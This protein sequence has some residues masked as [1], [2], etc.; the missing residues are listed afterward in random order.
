MRASGL[1]N[2]VCLKVFMLEKVIFRFTYSISN[3][4]TNNI[5]V[6]KCVLS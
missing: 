6:Q 2:H 3:T 4:H 1:V 5:H